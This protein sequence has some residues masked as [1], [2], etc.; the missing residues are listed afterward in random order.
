MKSIIRNLM[1]VSAAVLLLS[2]CDTDKLEI[3][4]RGSNTTDEY[5]T[6]DDD[7][8]RQFIAAIYS[9]IRGGGFTYYMGTG[10]CHY[11]IIYDLGCM[12]QEY[13]DQWEYSGTSQT[14]NYSMTWSYYYQIIYWCNMLIEWMPSNNVATESVKD[15]IVAEARAI[16]AI[17]MMQLVMLWGNPPLADHLMMGTEGNTDGSESLDW[18]QSE[19]AEVAEDLPSKS[20]ASGQEA[21]GGRL[22]KEAV[23]AYLG[24]AYL[25]DQEYTLAASTLY[26]KVISTGLY[27]LVS[28][29]SDINTSAIDFSAENMWEYDF[30]EEA[31][32]SSSQDG[33]WDVTVF[34]GISPSYVYVPE[35]FYTGTCWAMGG[36][37]SEEF[38]AFMDEHDVDADGNKSARYRGTLAAY[39]DLLDETVYT[40]SDSSQKGIKY[41]VS[42]CQGYFKIRHQT[43]E[44]DVTGTFPYAFNCRNVVYMR[45][46][47]VL[48]NYAEAIAQGGT[49][50][51]MSALEAV[52]LVRTRA[53]LSSL[54]SLSLDDVKDERRA[55]LYDEGQRFIDLVRW[56]DA[57]SELA[58]CGKYSYTFAGYNDGDNTTM[59]TKSDWYVIA[60]ATVGNGFVSGKHELFPYPEDELANNDAIEQNPGW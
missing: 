19:L 55:E 34:G 24:K 36:Y 13:A 51:S 23:Y 26:S 30:T 49:A 48:L 38:G 39:E 17:M 14:T 56:G 37:C 21:I 60:A 43:M 9:K 54:T 44:D 41:S 40:Y 31:S 47:E 46:A 4:Q 59:Q 5:V 57:A 22:T 7:G 3:T 15:R 28:D 16:R 1:L 45:Y 25:Y 33:M 6:A 27:S 52:N 2:A 32:L 18:I 10:T 12:A 8:V 11:G 20:S 53:G 29:F 50:S 42:D 58:D 35:G